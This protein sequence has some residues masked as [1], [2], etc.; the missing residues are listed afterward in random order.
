M[1]LDHLARHIHRRGVLAAITA[2]LVPTRAGAQFDGC[3][4]PGEGCT[5]LVQCCTGECVTMPLN[6]NSG[7]CGG[8]STAD[9][10]DP[11]RDVPSSFAEMA[12]TCRLDHLAIDCEDFDCQEDAQDFLDAFPDDPCGLDGPAGPN[13]DTRGTPGVACED[14]PRC[15]SQR[16]RLSRRQRMRRRRRRT[17]RQRI[18]P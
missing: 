13:N 16:T 11:P 18:W 14:R 6:P 1:T 5:L 15:S 7:F 2:L 17:T 4:G 10:R 12:A 8:T 3:A 9:R